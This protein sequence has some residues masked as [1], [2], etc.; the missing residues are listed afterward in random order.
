MEEFNTIEKVEELFRNVNGLGENNSFFV[1]RQDKQNV[2]GMVAGMEYPYDGLLINASEKGIAMFYLKAGALSGLI[3][4]AN[5]AKMKLEKENYIFIPSDEIK[6]IKVKN[7]ALL[8]SKTKRI[9]INTTDGKSHKLYARVEEKD[10]PYHAEN[11]ARFIE[12][13]S[14]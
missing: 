8:N 5:P 2:S 12:K 1:A 13:Y 9:E 6:G 7:F 10:F 14:K 3:T 11:F 4:L